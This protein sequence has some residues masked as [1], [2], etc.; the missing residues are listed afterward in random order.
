MRI[1]TGREHT[2]GS[3]AKLGGGGRLNR[4]PLAN[5]SAHRG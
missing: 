1:L 4:A 5:W 3:K 2:L